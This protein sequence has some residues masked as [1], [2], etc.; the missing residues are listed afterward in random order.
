MSIIEG[1]CN[2]CGQRGPVTGFDSGVINTRWCPDTEACEERW[3]DRTAAGRGTVVL[4]TTN[5]VSV[6]TTVTTTTT[7]TTR[8][9]HPS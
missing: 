6:T 7:R 2:Y 3:L 1:I 9:G 8:K 4:T 5:T